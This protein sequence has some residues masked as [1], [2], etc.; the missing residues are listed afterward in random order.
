M[1]ADGEHNASHKRGSSGNDS[2]RGKAGTAGWPSRR[3]PYQGPFNPPVNGD[4]D[5]NGPL[6]GFL[7]AASHTATPQLASNLGKT[8]NRRPTRPLD[9]CAVTPP[10]IYDS[11]LPSAS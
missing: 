2:H 11:S 9:T 1:I 10:S 6:S 7:P 8:A 3:H 5:G 4:G